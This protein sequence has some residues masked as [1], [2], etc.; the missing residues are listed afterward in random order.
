MSDQN[1]GF[2]L[3]IL[4]QADEIRR[5]AAL[6]AEPWTAKNAKSATEGVRIR[7][8]REARAVVRRKPRVD[9]LAMI[10]RLLAKDAAHREAGCCPEPLA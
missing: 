3:L 6:T 8:F 9:F 10:R 5:L 2:G 7:R 4:G 1:P